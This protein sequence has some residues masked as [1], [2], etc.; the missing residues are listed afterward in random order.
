MGTKL[1]DD[2]RHEKNQPWQSKGGCHL[3]STGDDE[4]KVLAVVTNGVQQPCGQ[5]M[6]GKW[7][8]GRR[9]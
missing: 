5:K 6:I 1:I 3:G 8:I 2:A 9:G 7:R 4:G